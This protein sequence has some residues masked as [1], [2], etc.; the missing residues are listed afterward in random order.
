MRKSPDGAVACTELLTRARVGTDTGTV[1]TLAEGPGAVAVAMDSAVAV[2]TLGLAGVTAWLA[3]HTRRSVMVAERAQIEALKARA[4]SRSHKI[5]IRLG[6]VEWPP[7]EPSA[8]PGGSAQPFV[9]TARLSSERDA[10]RLLRVVGLASV[11]NEGL[12]TAEI[13]LSGPAWFLPERYDYESS[14]SATSD[15]RGLALVSLPPAQEAFFLM[16][17]QHDIATWLDLQDETNQRALPIAAEVE[18]VA[19]DPYD[20][21]VEDYARIILEAKPLS[22]EADTD[23]WSIAVAPGSSGGHALGGAP[24]RLRQ[25]SIRRKWF[26]SRSGGLEL[27]L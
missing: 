14:L 26:I 18:L 10:H 5:S 3:W 9:G 8:F 22:I 27:A 7:C 16:F 12:A 19:S 4:D 24:A 25:S 2:G 21:G 17:A 11:A 6:E 15:R 23:M 13:S 1:S 20:D